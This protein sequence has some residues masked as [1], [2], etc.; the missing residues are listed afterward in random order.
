MVLAI[1]FTAY[2]SLQ[3]AI[4]SASTITI[5]GDV[6]R[7]L[8]LLR[9]PTLEEMAMSPVEL[10]VLVF[11]LRDLAVRVRLLSPDVLARS[12]YV[13]SLEERR[14]RPDVRDRHSFS[15]LDLL[16]LLDRDFEY[17]FHGQLGLALV[18]R[19]AAAKRKVAHVCE[20]R[21]VGR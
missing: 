6:L 3:E 13:S 15:E 1:I 5:A 17:R 14:L 10:F 20:S 8:I 19:I 11:R 21:G 18:G 9:E 2:D 16:D 7:S 12:K 4:D